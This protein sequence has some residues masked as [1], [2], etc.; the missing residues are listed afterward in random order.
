MIACRCTTQSYTWLKRYLDGGIPAAKVAC[1]AFDLGEGGTIG[2]GVE[3]VRGRGLG[4]V[5]E[6]DCGLGGG[7]GT[8]V[9]GGAEGPPGLGKG[10][11]RLAPLRPGLGEVE[12]PQGEVTE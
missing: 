7:R 2:R 10:P 12:P 8:G 6:W 1:R 4:E 5:R 11:E 9:L 3:V